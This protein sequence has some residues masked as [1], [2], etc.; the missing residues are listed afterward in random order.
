MTLCYLPTRFR[1]TML[2]GI[3]SSVVFLIA[4]CASAITPIYEH[5][6]GALPSICFMLPGEIPLELVT[7]PA[8]SI[9]MMAN[10]KPQAN[11]TADKEGRIVYK[12]RE[13]AL[14]IGKF[15]VT[16]AQ[17]Q[18]VMRTSQKEL[19][20]AARPGGP[21]Y[22]VGPDLPVY[23]VSAEQAKE[24]CNRLNKSLPGSFRYR[25][26]LPNEA[27]WEYACRAGTTSE[28]NNGRDL[29]ARNN[30]SFTLAELAWYRGN[31]FVSTPS[32]SEVGRKAPNA[33]GLYDM[34]GNVQELCL[35]WFMRDFTSAYKGDLCARR[36]GSWHDSPEDCTVTA[37]QPVDASIPVF[38]AGFR[39]A[40]K[41]ASDIPKTPVQYATSPLH[42]EKIT[43]LAVLVKFP[44]DPPDVIIPKE[45]VE[46][47]L[48]EKKYRGYGNSCSI[49]DFVDNQSFGRCEL[50]YLV[51]DYVVADHDRSYY[52]QALNYRGADML[53]K[54]AMSKL[55]RD[56]D[57]TTVS[58]SADGTIKSAC[59]LYSRNSS[60]DGLWP[61]AHWFTPMDQIRLPGGL[62]SLQVLICGI[63]DSPTVSILIH[64]IMHQTFGLLDYVDYGEKSDKTPKD[65]QLVSHGLGNH[66]IMGIGM[67]DRL[68]NLQTN[69]TALAGPFR[70]RLGWMKALPLPSKGKVRIPAS[71][72]YGYI[73]RNP[74]NP[75]EYFLLENRNADT[76]FYRAL[77]S[78]GLAIWHVDDAVTDQEEDE[79]M[80]KEKHYEISL[81]QAGGVPLLEK[82]C[83][84]TFGHQTHGKDCNGIDTDYF[85]PPDRV[86]FNDT[87]TPDSLWW[88]G[89]P[90]GLDISNIEVDGR[91][92]I[93][94]IGP[95]PKNPRPRQ[96][97]QPQTQ[98]QTQQQ[99]QQNPPQNPLRPGRRTGQQQQPAQGQGFGPGRR[100]PGG[101][102]NTDARQ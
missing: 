87:S 36:G 70:Y 5:K 4:S 65:Q 61:Q 47:F 101:R 25:F 12:F 48:N 93:V 83:P 98:Q 69:P 15:E 10:R 96:Q 31:S 26:T 54:E 45:K 73:Y 9:A 99:R 62:H 66:C 79:E 42:P 78:H 13:N 67:Y 50:K 53:I 57:L 8:G 38:N 95:D 88:D 43:G 92:L 102:P 3:L 85:Y 35:D 76:S 58:R 84:G 64:E 80:T 51:S 32:A 59:V 74:Q 6:D 82:T 34:H 86:V 28:L 22:G 39:V 1:C 2:S 89:S 77:P 19:T 27:E 37:C 23:D 94:T 11:E 46:Y 14:S 33:W 40:L 20:E 55:P 68:T 72:E 56:F 24:F 16:Q 44:D 49:F 75:D 30:Q 81:E 91:D 100:M 97:V 90:S 18:A 71:S 21:L 60:F 7:L 63:Q 29:R 41:P 52:Q 17:W